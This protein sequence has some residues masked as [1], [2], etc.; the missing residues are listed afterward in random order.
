MWTGVRPRFMGEFP[1][2][3]R[4]HGLGTQNSIPRR[5]PLPSHLYFILLVV[6]VF[7]PELGYIVHIC[8]ARH[9]LGFVYFIFG[10]MNTHSQFNFP[11]N[12]C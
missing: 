7:L 1:S 10:T 8:R 2:P 6:F 3:N 4:K 11:N 9:H 12:V 5:A